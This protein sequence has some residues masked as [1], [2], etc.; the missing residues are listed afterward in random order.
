MTGAAGRRLEADSANG[1][2][3]TAHNFLGGCGARICTYARTQRGVFNRTALGVLSLCRFRVDRNFP[4]VEHLFW[5]LA[6]FEGE[7][8]ILFPTS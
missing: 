7:S 5:V 1:N 3:W 8:G 2:T 4:P 6:N